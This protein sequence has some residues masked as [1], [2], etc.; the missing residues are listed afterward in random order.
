MEYVKGYFTLERNVV[1]WT[2]GELESRLGFRPG[3]LTTQG[4]RV[5][6]LRRQPTVGEFAFA[7]STLY[8][9]AEGLV[10]VAQR[11]NVP[12]PH[13]WL[14]QR[15]VKV[16]PNLPHTALEQY[17][18]ARSPVE[19]WQLLVSIPA[20]EIRRLNGRDMYWR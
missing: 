2:L 20:E 8:S 6:L 12:I 5:L 10:P 14:G 13:A 9:D 19:Q 17:P 15:L 11:R 4:A 16:E 18:R 1:G 7:G 3:R